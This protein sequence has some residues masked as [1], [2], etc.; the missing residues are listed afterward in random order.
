MGTNNK[1]DLNDLNS[2]SLDSNTTWEDS[3]KDDF[4]LTMDDVTVNNITYGSNF[5][6]LDDEFDISKQTNQMTEST[7][8]PFAV[9]KKP[10]GLFKFLSKNKKQKVE[11]NN[12]L[13]NYSIR[14]EAATVSALDD[15]VFK[16]TNTLEKVSVS[17]KSSKNLSDTDS[18]GEDAIL[19]KQKK[20]PIIGNFSVKYQ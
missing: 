11:E 14:T 6:N 17:Q 18:S 12:T 16:D 1:D 10:S 20:L 7:M 9:K 15:D 19:A 8:E 4:D 3:K 2:D 13:E 5:D